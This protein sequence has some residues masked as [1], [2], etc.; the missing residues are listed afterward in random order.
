MRRNLPRG[1]GGQFRKKKPADKEAEQLSPGRA[2]SEEQEAGEHGADQTSS[3][4]VTHPVKVEPPSTPA[5]S[6]GT[7]RTRVSSSLSVQQHEAITKLQLSAPMDDP[8]NSSSE[9]RAKSKRGSTP[10]DLKQSSTNSKSRSSSAAGVSVPRS[11]R[12]T[13]SRREAAASSSSSGSDGDDDSEDDAPKRVL[14]PRI[15][16]AASSAALEAKNKLMEISPTAPHIRQLKALKKKTEENRRTWK[17]WVEIPNGACDICFAVHE[18][19]KDVIPD[20]EE[21]LIC[22]RYASN[23]QGLQ[24]D[25]ARC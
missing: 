17:G 11:L 9:I 10:R 18:E 4:R 6:G 25:Y 16:Q 7:R 13:R 12:A 8:P 3:S 23:S 21:K 5:I 15:S 22:N 19:L 1:P 14:R 20:P 24:S 2:G